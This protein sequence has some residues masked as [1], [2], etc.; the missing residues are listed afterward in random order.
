MD[1]RQPVSSPGSGGRGA[2]R[3]DPFF[4]RPD[5][6]PQGVAGFDTD[7]AQPMRSCPY[8][9]QMGLLPAVKEV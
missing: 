4:M 7:T 3:R 9:F 5:P 8:W 2:G 1:G 6:Q